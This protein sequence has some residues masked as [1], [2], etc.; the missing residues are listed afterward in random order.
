MTD[1]PCQTLRERLHE[2]FKDIGK[3]ARPGRCEVGIA[4]F[5][6]LRSVLTF[7]TPTT[8]PSNIAYA[9]QFAAR[10]RLYWGIGLL[11]LGITHLAVIALGS[12]R[13][14][15]GMLVIVT[16]AMMWLS[17]MAYS[18]IPYAPYVW[19][20]IAT[21]LMATWIYGCM[22]W[23]LGKHKESSVLVRESV[24]L[25]MAATCKRTTASELRSEL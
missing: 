17:W 1:E 18:L 23:H 20:N 9:I 22:A 13:A 6:I 21:A 25:V 11:L 2:Q 5:T 19:D 14:R 12:E 3:T 4:A 7:I 15:G 10:P 24:K 8:T 16:G